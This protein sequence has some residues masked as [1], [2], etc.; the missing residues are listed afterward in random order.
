MALSACLLFDMLALVKSM[1][2]PYGVN[3]YKIRQ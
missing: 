1:K 2:H 3:V